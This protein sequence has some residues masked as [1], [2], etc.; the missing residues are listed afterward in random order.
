[1]NEYNWNIIG[2]YQIN[3]IIKFII[4]LNICVGI[5]YIIK[6]R[7]IKITRETNLVTFF[8]FT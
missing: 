2:K 5:K 1:M 8:L 3:I 6:S 4:R 7:K